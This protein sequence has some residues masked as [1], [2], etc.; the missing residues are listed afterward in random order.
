MSDIRFM[1]MA[2]FYPA[3]L[4][5]FYADR[6]GL[7]E[8]DYATQY[9]TLMDDCFAWADFWKRNLEERGGFTAEE[10]VLNAEPLQKRWAAEHGARYSADNWAIDIMHAQIETF[11][12]DVLFPH[13]ILFLTPE[14]RRTLKRRHPSIQLQLAWDGIASHDPEMFAGTDIMMTWLDRSVEYYAGAGFDTHQMWPGFEGRIL[15]RLKENGDAPEWTNRSYGLS[16]VG[17]I[18]DSRGMHQRRRDILGKVAYKH[19]LTLYASNFGLPALKH[20]E[21]QLKRLIKSAWQPGHI[22]DLRIHG[23]LRRRNRGPA[24]GLRMYG[25][26]ANSKITL[27]SHLD[28]TGDR[29][30]NMRM[31][32]ATGCGACLLTDW[33]PNLGEIFVP[34]EEVVAYRSVD[35]CL[36]KIRY[37]EDHPEVAAE[38]ARKGQERTLSR[39]S[40]KERVQLAAQK[41]EQRLS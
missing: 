41:F 21:I 1:H 18:M 6:P 30:G 2:S 37:L 25:I 3:Y 5:K 7:A 38:I 12:P 26:L 34:D 28:G 32:E 22:E 33:K 11:R 40:L 29:A 24:F 31:Y 8:Q 27:N 17:S 13:D 9:R 10:I 14:E 19:G 20:Y 23:A 39:Y 16:F 15:T 35:E 36:E 4:K